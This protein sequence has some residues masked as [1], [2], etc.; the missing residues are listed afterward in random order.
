MSA[1]LRLGVF[2][3]ELNQGSAA[4]IRSEATC[5]LRLTGL[6]PSGTNP[7]NGM[8]VLRDD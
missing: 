5:L 6:A 4:F 2:L 1:I 3:H 7:R 8:M